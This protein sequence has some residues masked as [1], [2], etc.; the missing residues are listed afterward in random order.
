MARLRRASETSGLYRAMEFVQAAGQMDP[1]VTRLIDWQKAARQV[2]DN[3]G[4]PSDLLIPAEELALQ[5]QAAQE[6][7]QEATLNEQM[8]QMAMQ[9]TSGQEQGGLA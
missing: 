9:M 3:E 2:A 7:A 8:Q 4:V 5:D 6:A 1:N